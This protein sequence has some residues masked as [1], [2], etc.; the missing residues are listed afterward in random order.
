MTTWAEF[1]D[2]GPLLE[3]QLVGR[4]GPGVLKA[5]ALARLVAITLVQ[6]AWRNTELEDFHASGQP[7]RPSDYAMFRANVRLTRELLPALTSFPIDIDSVRGTLTD[8]RRLALEDRTA[9][10]FCG[11][12]WRNVRKNAV[13]VVDTFADCIVTTGES[14]ARLLYAAQALWY[15]DNWWGTPDFAARFAGSL[16]SH[17]TD[18]SE[19]AIEQAVAAPDTIGED[20]FRDTLFYR[21]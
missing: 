20:L 4:W 12:A 1:A 6:R 17:R 16:R 15:G 9:R 5:D 18:L 14:V 11:P 2:A 7:E 21:L 19:A 10:Q 8:G 13:A 3:E